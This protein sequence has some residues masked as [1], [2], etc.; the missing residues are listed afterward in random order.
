MNK[1]VDYGKKNFRRECKRMFEFLTILI[2]LEEKHNITSAIR[3]ALREQFTSDDSY[4]PKRFKTKIFD[5]SENFIDSL[6]N[7]K[8][9]G[10][11]DDDNFYRNM[12]PLFNT[13]ENASGILVFSILFLAMVQLFIPKI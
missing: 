12:I 9:K 8:K 2:K 11:N 13:L 6:V 7:E 1:I 10:V 4:V 5:T 3:V